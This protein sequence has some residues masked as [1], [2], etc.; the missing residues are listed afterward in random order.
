VIGK[1]LQFS[2]ETRNGV[3][4][5]FIKGSDPTAGGLMNAVTAYSQTIENAD[6]AADVEADAMKALD[7]AAAAA[8]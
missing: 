2:E 7:M 6:T 5:M 4:D 8:R 1:A 3:L